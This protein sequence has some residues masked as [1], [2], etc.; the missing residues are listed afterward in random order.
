MEVNVLITIMNAW[1]HGLVL[2]F[3]NGGQVSFKF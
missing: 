3:D 2:G 1:D